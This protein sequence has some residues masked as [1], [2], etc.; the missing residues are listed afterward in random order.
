MWVKEKELLLGHATR[1]RL[2]CPF[3]HPGPL[4]QLGNLKGNK[5]LL[6]FGGRIPPEILAP[7]KTPK[8]GYFLLGCRAARTQP[9]FWHFLSV[10]KY[11]V[12]LL[13][14]ESESNLACRTHSLPVILRDT[15]TRVCS[16]HTGK[17][18]N[19][20]A[21]KYP[22]RTFQRGDFLMHDVHS[23]FQSASIGLLPCK[24][25]F[26]IFLYLVECVYFGQTATVSRS[27]LDNSKQ[28]TLHLYNMNCCQIQSGDKKNISSVKIYFG[29]I[30]PFWRE[31]V[32]ADS[33]IIFL[34]QFVSSV[35]KSGSPRHRRKNRDS[36]ASSTPS[37]VSKT[38]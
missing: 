36:T 6:H 8:R 21:H 10:S 11:I 18:V 24:K 23:A 20:S 31:T 7:K 17:D 34:D 13:E 2:C 22:A 14:A 27:I 1:M 37:T 30:V 25:L 5:F 38:K 32:C 29:Y 9:G 15:T 35:G 28:M 4:Y 26:L 33:I 16:L 19:S 3:I 12:S